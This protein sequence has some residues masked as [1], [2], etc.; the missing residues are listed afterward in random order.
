M[1]FLV[2]VKIQGK[3]GNVL[4][5]L[6]PVPP[7]P[8]YQVG[9]LCMGNYTVLTRSISGCY[10]GSFVHVGGDN[11]DFVVVQTAKACIPQNQNKAT[12]FFPNGAGNSYTYLWYNGETTVQSN[13]FSPGIHTVTV[14]DIN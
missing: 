8:P 4:L 7:L 10:F 11:F 13:S 3:N 9:G 14:T 6:D 2:T 12:V 1:V 5:Y